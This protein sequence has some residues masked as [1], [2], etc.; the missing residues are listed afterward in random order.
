ML[1]QVGAQYHVSCDRLNTPTRLGLAYQDLIELTE[2]PATNEGPERQGYLRLEKRLDG[3]GRPLGTPTAQYPGEEKNPF[4]EFAETDDLWAEIIGEIGDWYQVRQY[5]DANFYVEKDRVAQ[6][7]RNEELWHEAAFARTEEVWTA[8][9]EDAGLWL[10]TVAAGERAQLA[11]TFQGEE[12]LPEEYL[13]QAES[14]PVS[15]TV[16]IPAGTRVFRTGGAMEALTEDGVPAVLP[17]HPS[18]YP[19]HLEIFSGS[20]RFFC[21]AQLPSFITYFGYCVRPVPGAEDSYFA[22]SDLL[23][24]M[25]EDGGAADDRIE[26][27]FLE[28]GEAYVDL[29][30][31]QF[32]ELHNCVLSL[33]FGNG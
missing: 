29:H 19:D 11:L 3:E 5:H 23:F 30:P 24:R 28:E 6:A 13:V 26:A 25:G 7:V 17:A 4:G 1:G 32:L 12:A 16:Y 14:A 22:V 9:G 33:F 10:W 21:D 18:D 20:G 27:F 8:S 2:R 15:Y 31:G